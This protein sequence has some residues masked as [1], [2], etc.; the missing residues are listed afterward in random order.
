MDNRRLTDERSSG[1]RLVLSLAWP[2]LFQQGLTLCVSLSDRILAGWFL[3]MDPEGMV[4]T[5]AAMT[6]G[7]YIDWLI[8]CYTIVVS[9][10]STALVARFVGAQDWKSAN[11][12]TNQSVLLAIIA[13]LTGVILAILFLPRLV[14]L[15][16][17]KDEAAR[18]S[19][20]LIHI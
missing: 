5:Q 13:G 2:V 16:G 7:A 9:V 12:V 4:A 19:L 18:H 3:D 8:S 15:L 20:S 6:T 10:G 17:L 14:S 11:R 1:W